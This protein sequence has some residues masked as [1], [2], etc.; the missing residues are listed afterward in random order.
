M[1]PGK[2]ERMSLNEILA[3]D[4]DLLKSI[5]LLLVYRELI[6]RLR[7]MV[8]SHNAKRIEW[9]IGS[10]ELQLSKMLEEYDKK[11]KN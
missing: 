10:I 11:E 2:L 6:W 9:K 7:P 8:Y 5:D 1:Y 3:V 4:I